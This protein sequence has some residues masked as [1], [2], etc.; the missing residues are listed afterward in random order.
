[1]YPVSMPAVRIDWTVDMLDELPDDGNRYELID[2]E[3]FVTPAPSNWHQLVVGALH[4]RLRAYLRPSTVARAM[5]SPSDVWRG[6]R[7]RN[8]VQPD[9][10]AVSLIGGKQPE[11]PYKLGDVLLTIEV[12][13]PSNAAYDYQ[14][15]RRLYLANGVP[16]YWVVSTDARTFARWRGPRGD[17]ELLSNRIEWQPAGIPE[18]LIIDIPEFFDDALG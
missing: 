8:R 7:R 2:G 17:G 12:E 13:S 4:A 3:L 15:K 9:V 10:F 18:P 6:D 14:T 11:Y 16:E 1:M 5:F